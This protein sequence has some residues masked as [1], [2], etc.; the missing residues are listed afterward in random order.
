MGVR[1]FTAAQVA[2]I[3]GCSRSTVIGWAERGIVTPDFEEFYSRENVLAFIEKW[4]SRKVNRADGCYYYLVKRIMAAFILG[5]SETS[6][7]S[8]LEREGVK[9]L[10]P[11]EDDSTSY[12]KR[13]EV[14]KAAKAI[15]ERRR[16]K[17]RGKLA[18]QRKAYME[19]SLRSDYKKV[20]AL[21]SVRK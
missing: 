13:A 9:A 2:R 1:V 10:H 14:E 4:G 6:V 12:W 16:K 7:D 5:V 19:K 11:Y 8:I 15:E 3:V 17:A 20:Q 21:A 18:R